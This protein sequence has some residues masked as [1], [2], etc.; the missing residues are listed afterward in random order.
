MDNII[1][2]ISGIIGIAEVLVSQNDRK[3]ISNLIKKRKKEASSI[4]K[5]ANLKL[6]T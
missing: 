2:I 5:D 3:N 1:T 6:K 4:L